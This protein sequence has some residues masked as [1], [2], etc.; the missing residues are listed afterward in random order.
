M[1]F[2]VYDSN[3][4]MFLRMIERG[5]RPGILIEE[6]NYHLNVVPVDRGSNRNILHTFAF[7]V[8]EDT[9]LLQSYKVNGQSYGVC[10]IWKSDETETYNQ[11][12]IKH[13]ENELRKLRQY[14]TEMYK[15]YPFPEEIP[16]CDRP[17]VVHLYG[18]DDASYTLC[19]KT[20]HQIK[21][22]IHMIK[23][24]PCV[25]TESLIAQMRFVFTN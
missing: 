24:D 10:S 15:V 17:Y 12:Q 13:Y 2:R 6:E 21:A 22:F 11:M 16:S 23:Q 7:K 25:C 5:A 14:G 1:S 8:N 4:R 3:F 9:D 18:C 19:L 20:E